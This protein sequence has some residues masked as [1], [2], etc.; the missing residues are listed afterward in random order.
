[1]SLKV[2]HNLLVKI[3][4]IILAVGLWAVVDASQSKISVFPG[5]IP[6]EHKGLN[7]KL[8]AIA[9]EQEVGIKIFTDKNIWRR[10]SQSTFSARV[11]L[12]GL[13]EGIYEL[14]VVVTTN[15]PE[16]QIVEKTP[17]SIMVRI[18]PSASKI[19]PVSAKTEGEIAKGKSISSTEFNPEKVTVSGAKGLIDNISEA[20]V[21]INTNNQ[22]ESFSVTSDLLAFDNKGKTIKTIIFDP[23][24]VNVKIN[25]EDESTL[26]NVGVLLNTSGSVASGFQVEKIVL[27]PS[28]VSIRG[29]ATALR[30]VNSVSTQPVDLSGIAEAKTLDAI[31]DIPSG[32]TTEDNLKKIRVSLDVKEIKLNQDF[33]IPVNIS[34]LPSGYIVSKITPSTVGIVLNGPLSLI[35]N[36]DSSKLATVID[37]SK[38]N[39]GENTVNIGQNEILGIGQDIKVLAVSPTSVKLEVTN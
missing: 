5:R 16:V 32:I 14:P 34:K 13:E 36:I 12:T 28:T 11:D 9:D 39:V 31:L 21:Q 6:I 10:L 20:V 15:I 25:I 2:T 7:N 38:L 33:S 29:N 27:N 8:A 24:R 30:E 37:G 23:S 19:V 22:S 4:S 1:M 3:I 17:S 26:K 35:N 18:E